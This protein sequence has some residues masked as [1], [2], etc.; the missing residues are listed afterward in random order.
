MTNNTGGPAFPQG[1][2]I[3]DVWVSEG[4]VTMRDYFAAKA[5]QSIISRINSAQYHHIGAE[6]M[7][8]DAYAFADAMLKE[9]SK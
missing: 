7:A 1:K 4:G 2:G 5:M 3:G 9:R 8:S 6:T